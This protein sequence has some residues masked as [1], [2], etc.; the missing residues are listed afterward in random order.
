MR[1]LIDPHCAG[2]GPSDIRP[3]VYPPGFL[4]YVCSEYSIVLKLDGNSVLSDL[5]YLICLRNLFKSRSSQIFITKKLIS[6]TRA[7]GVLSYHLI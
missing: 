4:D 7:Q 5:G 6:F 1:L 3:E 2:Y